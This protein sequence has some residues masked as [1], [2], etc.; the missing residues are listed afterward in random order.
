MA[1]DR[2]GN[3]LVA[4]AQAKDTAWTVD[5]VERSPGGPWGRPLALSQPASHVASPQLAVAGDSVVAVW[6]RYDGKNL[7]VQAA[8][9]DAK[10]HG[11]TAPASLSLGG[12]DAQAPSVAVNARGD[13]VAVWASVGLSG[14]SIQASYRPAGGTW[15]APAPL[16]TPLAGTAAPDVVIDPSGKAVAVWAATSGSGWRVQTAIRS[17]DG[18]WSK[19][20]ALSGPDATG[21]IAPQLA[22]EGTND[23][24]AVWSRS[25][26]D[27][28]VIEAS[29][30]NAAK[31]TWSPAVQLFPVPHDALA[32][33]VAVDKRGD[34]VI[35][36]TS[37][38]Q[39]GLSLMASY[40]RA[41]RPWSSATS[42]SGRASG[43]LSPQ[44]AIDAR[45]NALAVW[46]QF[47]GG[48]SRVH[49]SSFA[50]TGGWSA[51]RVL[52]KAGA[53]SLTPDVALD[54]D[55]DGA[56]AWARF[57]GGSFVIQGDG[58]DR[59]GPALSK[60]MVPATGTVGRRLTFT[61]V[62]RDVWT[63]VGTIRWTFGDG[64]AGSGHATRHVYTRPGRYVARV[65]ATDA[66]GHVTSVRRVVK[67]VAG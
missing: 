48:F 55:G 15:Q 62:P 3:A 39:S 27:S 65:T 20:F 1:F 7:I 51:A 10:M 36:W 32:P 24:L 53:D 37:S 6:N 64:T 29:T 60:L 44:V 46:T 23:V 52:S 49:A 30:M 41:G 56:A 57:N 14:W 22:L 4:W 58:Y 67:I 42:V 16:Q 54:D 31:N 8:S 9:R 66:F 11:W 45:G 59:N 38:D 47:V 61:V 2:K 28:T 35:I 12:R 19:P 5:I 26:G 40:R 25:I 33:S 63:T 34:G 43:S 21:S 13:A 17:V 50:A 18:S